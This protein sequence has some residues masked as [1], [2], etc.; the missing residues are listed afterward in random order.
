[1]YIVID[2]LGMVGGLFSSIGGVST[3][4]IALLTR[5]RFISYLSKNLY[6]ARNT[7]HLTNDT[8]TLPD[9]DLDKIVAPHSQ[10]NY[11]TLKINT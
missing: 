8:K 5:G 2:V 7:E 11:R 1:L 10:D 6:L 4:V 3:V 9:S